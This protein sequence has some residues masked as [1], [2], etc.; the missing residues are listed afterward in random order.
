MYIYRYIWIHLFTGYC[1]WS[2]IPPISKFN[3]LSS[4]QRLFCHIPLRRDQLDWDWWFRFNNSPIA[5][6][7]IHIYIH[8]CVCIYL[9]VYIHIN[10]YMYVYMYIRVHI[11]V[12]IYVYIN[13]YIHIYIHIYIRIYTFIHIY[14]NWHRYI[15]VSKIHTYTCFYEWTIYWSLIFNAD[16]N[17]TI[18]RAC[19][20]TL[21]RNL[22]Q[23]HRCALW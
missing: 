8:I 20:V 22:Q 10:I 9:C 19:G 3:R 16:N 18:R 14:T 23:G 12:Y 21:R 17:D 11:C 2:V 4:S 15:Q 13:M 5:T 7:C 6:A 1:V